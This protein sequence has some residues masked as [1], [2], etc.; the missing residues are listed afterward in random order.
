MVACKDSCL[1]KNFPR[2]QLESNYFIDFFVVWDNYIF[3]YIA[4]ELLF[5]KRELNSYNKDMENRKAVNFS[6]RPS[7]QCVE[8]TSKFSFPCNIFDR[9]YFIVQL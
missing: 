7:I 2:Q 4:R 9:R 6:I 3:R 8:N 5:F 1:L